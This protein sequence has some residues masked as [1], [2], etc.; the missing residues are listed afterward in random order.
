[1]NINC[2]LVNCITPLMIA[3]SC[4]YTETVQVLLQEG[5]NVSS[6]DKVV[7][8]FLKEHADNNLQAKNMTHCS[9]AS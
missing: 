4:G 5:T 6:T 2:T 3:S 7:E 9:N 1:M 8:L